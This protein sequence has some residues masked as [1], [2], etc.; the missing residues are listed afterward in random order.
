MTLPEVVCPFDIHATY[1]PPEYV[2]EQI[3]GIDHQLGVRSWNGRVPR[4][5]G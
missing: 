2:M 1:G 3:K 5:R 4:R